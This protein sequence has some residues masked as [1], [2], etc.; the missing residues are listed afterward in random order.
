MAERVVSLERGIALGLVEDVVAVGGG[1]LVDDVG[2][3]PVVR[4]A[5]PLARERARKWPAIALVSEDDR[6]G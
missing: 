6:G 1:M 5:I 3:V 4:P 2:D